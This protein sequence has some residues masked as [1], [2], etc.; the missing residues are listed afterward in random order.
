MEKFIVINDG[1][2]APIL[3]IVRRVALAAG[4]A[5]LMAA[6]ASVVD[7]PM[8][9]P[10]GEAQ[11]SCGAQIGNWAI[12]ERDTATVRARLLSETGASTIRLLN[13]ETAGIMDHRPDRLNIRVG[14][15]NSIRRLS[16]G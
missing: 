6:C 7:P 12:G 2:M 13:E 9:A 8:A 1:R 3:R 10:T 5:G 4:C 14:P 16:C 11:L 15:N